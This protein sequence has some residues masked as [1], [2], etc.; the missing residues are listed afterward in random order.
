MDSFQSA[1]RKFPITRT[2][3][4]R[5]QN[6]AHHSINSGKSVPLVLLYF[7]AAFD[8]INH[9]RLLETLSDR[10]RLCETTQQ[11]FENYL[12]SLTMR[13]CIAT[14]SPSLLTALSHGVSQRSLLGSILFGR[15]LL[16]IFFA[17]CVQTIRRTRITLKIKALLHQ[18]YFFRQRCR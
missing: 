6:E 10:A 15:C 14:R 13:V 7:N 8:N 18:A 9:Y 5:I 17:T 4:I 2:I 12:T 1:H 3:M 11:W 16:G